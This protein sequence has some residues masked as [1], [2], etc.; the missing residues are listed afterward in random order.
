MRIQFAYSYTAPD[1][2][3]FKPD[4][5]AE[6]DDGVAASLIHSGI[7]RRAAAPEPAP[8]PAPA[9]PAAPKTVKKD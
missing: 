3:T 1:G 4:A 2:K 5:V 7:A 8:E 9:T 6:V